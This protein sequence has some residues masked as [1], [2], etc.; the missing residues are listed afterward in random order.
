MTVTLSSFGSSGF[1]VGKIG[2][3][4]RERERPR[5]VYEHVEILDLS[6]KTKSYDPS[7][8]VSTHSKTR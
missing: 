1:R 4:G 6:E 3:S 8:L 2:V 7:A 5:H